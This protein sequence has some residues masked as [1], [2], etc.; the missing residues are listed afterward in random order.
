MSMTIYTMTHKPFTPPQD[1]LYQP[2]QVGSALHENLGYL[3][4]NEGDNISEQNPYYS[5]LT[6]HYWVWKN[7]K[8]SDYVGCAHYR[9][10]LVNEKE[11][12]YTEP[13]LMELLKDYDMVTTKLLTLEYPY[14]D[15][16]DDRHNSGDLDALGEVIK[17]LEPRYY[18][19]Y[20][21]LVH[22][23]QTY[24]GNMFVMAKPL[25]DRYME[26]LFP[27]LFETQKRIDMT[28]YDGY[29]K[30]LFG[31]LSEFLLYVW[32]TANSIKVKEAKV[33]L[34][35]EKA[36]TK[37]LKQRIAEFFRKK[38][39]AGAKAYFWQYYKKRPDILMEVSD[40]NRECRLAMQAISS[41][42]WEEKQT[43]KSRLE[44]TTDFWELIEFYR[45]LNRLTLRYGKN[46]DT[47]E[48]LRQLA[49]EEEEREF[50]EKQQISETE[51]AVARKVNGMA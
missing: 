42:E 49:A 43:G 10:Y 34:I 29:Q 23:R 40:I 21:R 36:E 46:A 14:Y 27:L 22:G 30:R 7:D 1:A 33:G 20:I 31:F 18:D 6:G 4:D 25:Y 35:G 5:E 8:H 38:D 16:F 44:K 13:E 26:F 50:M 12:L 19:A 51:Y 41:L 9:R 28:G 17:E 39:I 3:S 24:F 45:F 15:A 2:L 11:Q 37:E 32:V 47:V 48:K